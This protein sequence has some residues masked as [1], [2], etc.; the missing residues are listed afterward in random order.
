VIIDG[1]LNVLPKPDKPVESGVGENW[2]DVTQHFGT[3][4]PGDY[5]SFIDK[6]GSGE[7]GEWLSVFNPFSKNQNI[8]LISQF[9][10]CLSSLSILKADYPEICSYPLLFEPSGLLPW[11]VSID[12][13][14]FCWETTGMSGKWSVVVIG[15]D[16]DPEKYEMSTCQFIEKIIT[17]T[18]SPLAIPS[19]WNDGE[20][21]FVPHIL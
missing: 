1:V 10:S 12:G 7:I 15:R 14:I 16:S 2:G 11:G 5:M 9:F 6:Y 4:L 8:N 3:P 21:N 18:I 17:S 19:D 20:I 13:D